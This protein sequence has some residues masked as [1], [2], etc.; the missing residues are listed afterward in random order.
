M[1]YVKGKPYFCQ[2]ETK[3]KS[4]PYLN[5]NIETDI[6]IV[7]G[8]ADGVIA[9]YYLS[10]KYDCVLVDKER[11]G[12]SCT[13]CATVLLEY[14]LDDF[15]KDLKSE[16]TDEE[17]V[18]VYNMGL[19]SIEKISKL[20][21]FKLGN[22]CHFAKKPS[23]LYS[24]NILDVPAIKEE[25]EFR[26]KHGFAVNYYDK[27]NNPFPFDIQAGLYAPN[28]GAEFNAYL[29]CKQLIEN[30]KNQDKIFENTDIETI[31]KQGDY[32]ISTTSYGQTIKSKKIIIST[33]FNWEAI[34]RDDLCDRFITYSIVTNPLN[35]DWKKEALMQDT[36]KPY[37]YFRLLPDKRIIFGGEDT[38]YSKGEIKDS[39]AVK[40]YEK[41]LK[42]LQNM[43]P[44]QSN[45]IKIDYQFCGFFAQ[46]KNNLGM[47]GKAEDQIYYFLSCGANGIINAF[48]GIE[49]LEDA[50]NNKHNKLE[51]LFTPLR[52]VD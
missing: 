22:D 50:F 30:S 41:L 28:G 12:A 6:L 2:T 40:K 51:H 20:I 5:E 42:K 10:P 11:I 14:Q 15:A 34:K 33:G 52:E 19:D 47:I 18:E 39:K 37:H 35:I 38:V 3:I 17:I 24:N 16:M 4:F 36:Q 27:D 23:F 32:Y 26:K 1:E 25:Y 9:N 43:F 49:I 31:E 7:G 46:T 44:A 45:D 29:F 13:S 48:Y 21:M 8:G